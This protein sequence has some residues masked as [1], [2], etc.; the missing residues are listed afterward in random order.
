MDD[1]FILIVNNLLEIFTTIV[2]VLIGYIGVRFK[3]FSKEYLD[4]KMKKEI[5]KQ[6][7][8]Y[9]EQ[10]GKNLSCEEKKMKARQKSYE[11]LKEKKINIS[12]TELEILIESSVKCL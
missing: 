8:M 9:V 12:N 5:I 7:V 10:T 2:M 6:T 3:N 11:W 4:D 1:I